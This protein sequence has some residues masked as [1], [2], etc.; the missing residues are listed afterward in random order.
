M[1]AHDVSDEAV[2]V[3]SG[4]AALDV[5]N[6]RALHA[7]LVEALSTRRSVHIDGSCVERADAAGL[8][9]LCA[10]M[11]EARR[12]GLTIR[13]DA[14]SAALQYAAALLGMTAHLEL[15]TITP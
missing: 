7:Q 2:T 3:I 14:P 6:A 9:L 10:G 15:A 12:R 1:D 5:A 4:V 13:C 11:Q 8:Q